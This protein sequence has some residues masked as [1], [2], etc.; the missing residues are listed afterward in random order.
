MNSAL[1]RIKTENTT[2]TRMSNQKKLV[3]VAWTETQHLTDR[4]ID[5]QRRRHKEPEGVTDGR[6]DRLTERVRSDQGAQLN[7]TQLNLERCTSKEL[8]LVAEIMNIFRTR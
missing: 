2:T 5:G 3:S 4:L 1:K 7:C 8:S 6:Q